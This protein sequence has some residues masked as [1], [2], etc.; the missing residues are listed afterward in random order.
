YLGAGEDGQDAYRL[1][2]DALAKAERVGVGRWVFHN[3]EYLVA[4][5]ALDDALALHTMRF[6][7]ELVAADDL[8][9]PSPSRAPGK[10]EVQ[11][12]GQLVESLHDDF[13]PAAFEDA[14][15]ERVQELI[16]V[17]SRGE[18]PELPQEVEPA[19][20]MDLEAALEASLSG[21]RS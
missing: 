8:D 12:A 1:L 21:A 2:H 18:E 5:R 19:G 16:E 7:D 9:L 11:M 3:R 20:G 13:D 10:R 17:K 4:V 14:Y 6:A 15:R